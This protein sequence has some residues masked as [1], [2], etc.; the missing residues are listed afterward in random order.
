MSTGD[1]FFNGCLGGAVAAG[2]VYVLP[3]LAK[4]WFTGTKLEFSSERRVLG[5]VLLCFLAAAGGVATLAFDHLTRSQAIRVG[6]ASEPL[7][8]GMFTAARDATAPK[9]PPAP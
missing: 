9:P 4:A 8:R 2:F 3:V 1:A 7:L 5:V 6:L